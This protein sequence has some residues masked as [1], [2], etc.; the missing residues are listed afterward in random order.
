[1]LDHLS[2]AVTDLERSRRFYD[3][4]MAAL[5]VP[6]VGID[7]ADGWV[8]YGLRSDA[9]APERSYLS[10]RRS[11][12]VVPATTAHV[13]F[14]AATA[15]QVDAFWHAGLAAGGRDDGPPGLRPH[16]HARYYAAFLIDPDGNRIEAVCHTA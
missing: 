3:A 10:L 11:D 6:A 16:Y 7:A 1:M 9:G 14:K 5:G 4:V 12:R 2:I 15:S 8:G 13:A